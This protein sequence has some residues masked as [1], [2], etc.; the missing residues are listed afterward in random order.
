MPPTTLPTKVH[1]VLQELSTAYLSILLQEEILSGLC[2]SLTLLISLYGSLS[3]LEGVVDNCE[4][5][6]SPRTVPLGIESGGH[7]LSS[8]YCPL[9]QD[10]GVKPITEA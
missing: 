4:A 9:H 1:Y 7:H 3:I 6:P 2:P 10:E 5:G 8:S